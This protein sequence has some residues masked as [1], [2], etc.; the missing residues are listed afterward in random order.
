MDFS[1]FIGSIYTFAN[2]IYN[3]RENFLLCDGSSYAKKD[4]QELYSVIGDTYR[5]HYSGGGELGEDF[6]VVPDLRLRYLTSDRLTESLGTIL[7]DTMRK[8]TGTFKHDWDF[9]PFLNA[10]KSDSPNTSG[11][12]TKEDD[13]LIKYYPNIDYSY[14]DLIT[15]KH[16]KFDSSFGIEG[17]EGVESPNVGAKTRPESVIMQFYILAKTN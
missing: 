3:N 17:Q 1:N 4:F 2:G 12:M 7:P 10:E 15:K 14:P 5:D 13:D 6:F 16:L 8:I 11:A 9:G